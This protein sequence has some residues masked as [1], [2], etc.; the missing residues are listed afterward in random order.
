VIEVVV[1]E[2]C[3]RCGI[4][5]DVCPTRVFDIGPDGV[6]FTARVDDCQTC[7]L[8]EAYCPT[9]A[10]FVAPYAERAPEG[11]PLADPEHLAR[12]GLLGSYRAGLGWGG[13]RTLTASISVM[14]EIPPR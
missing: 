14:P 13:G 10:L 2:R 12:T 5:V 3:I 1:A 9:D 7:Y 11:S 4:C 8:C 6:P